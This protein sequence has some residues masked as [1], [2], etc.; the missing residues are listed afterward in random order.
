MNEEY[1]ENNSQDNEINQDSKINQDNQIGNE[2]NPQSTSEK[3]NVTQ[4]SMISDADSNGVRYYSMPNQRNSYTNSSYQGGSDTGTV[5]KNNSLR[6]S[7]IIFGCII[8]VIVALGVSC[9]SVASNFWSGIY[10]TPYGNQNYDVPSSAYIAVLYVDG[11]IQSSNTDLFGTA[12]D[13]QHQWTLE[14]ID[15]L[16]Y[17]YNNSGIVLFIN[18]PGGG[19]YESDE[20][21]LKIKEYQEF[22]E[23][24]VYSAMGSMAASGG[25]YISAPCDKIF[26]N[27][28]CWT[29]SIGVTIGTLYDVSELLDNYGIKTVTITSGAN[30]AM[31][32]SVEPMT[33]EQQ[34]IFQGLVDESYEQF[35]EIVAEGR[36][37]TVDQVKSLADGRI[38]TAKQAVSVGLVD[39][40]GTLDEAIADM[41]TE[42]NLDYCEV[43]D[44]TYTTNSFL[45]TLF[46][47]LNLVDINTQGD[48]AALLQVME[49]ANEFPISYM[50]DVLK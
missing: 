48:V 10:N 30:K 32:S 23:N 45:G 11:T 40:I 47:K 49:N 24:P 29:G 12:V 6:N 4:P 1:N 26:A 43:V 37:M 44:I 35:V 39:E 25:Y 21:Y 41:Q 14:T 8:L 16:M 7:L 13:Y 34:A 33:A 15:N 46:S 20:L 36:G 42:Y 22:T 27:R 3:V 2:G 38:Y 19:V 9:N 17:D 5:K 28:N 31:G 18:S 50:C